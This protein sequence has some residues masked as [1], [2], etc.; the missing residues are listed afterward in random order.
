MK[1]LGIIFVEFTCY[2]FILLFC[3]ASISKILDFENF[4]IQIGQSPLLSAYAGIVS[5]FTIVIEIVISFLLAIPTTRRLGLYSSIGLMGAFTA[6]IYIILNY[7]EFI[8]CSCGGILEKMDW[9]THL[10]FNMGC[11]FIAIISYFIVE[12]D[13]NINIKRTISVVLFMLVFSSGIVVLLYYTSEYVIKKENNFIRRFPHH[14]VVEIDRYDLK[15]NSFYFAGY[16]NDKIYLGNYTSPF[17]LTEISKDLKLYKQY[18][19]KPE[20]YKKFKW[21]STKIKVAPPYVFLYDG[22]IPVIYK[23]Q[24]GQS[25]MKIISE[26]DA[27]F[28]DLESV[29]NDH[30]AL[31]SKS[32]H[33]GSN[34]L[35]ILNLSEDN[36]VKLN[37]TSLD[38]NG[39][40][41]T[42]G[43]L[44]YSPF[45]E[46]LIY[47]YY[48][49]NRFD[50][51]DKTIS[52]K[53]IHHTIDTISRPQIKVVEM[54]NGIKKM[55]AP[56]Q[57]V[58]AYA[59]VQQ[60]IL[61]NKSN[62]I[63]RYELRKH[64]KNN[65]V[66]DMY[67]ISKREYLGSFYVENRGDNKMT[68]MLATDQFFYTLIG[69]EIVRYRYAQVI[70]KQLIRESPKPIKE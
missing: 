27:Y 18:L 57:I 45:S 7:S 3:Y 58:N 63:G 41:E 16:D 11:I 70:S 25:E 9:N 13:R 10:I 30:I 56:P 39:L 53:S 35:G 17:L 1:K 5:Y 2:F 37:D 19:L 49:K 6:Y 36:Q 15:F 33:S 54:K 64:W 32:S 29:D 12:K 4:Q 26:N 67:N 21:S 23:A 66:V 60:D 65:S 52:Q 51:F 59:T 20:N 42:D 34:T 22:K 69:S 43:Q 28:S 40:F 62:L 38:G 31:R 55:A 47:V 61:F 48:Y 14:G 8:P 24:I 44:L 46:S 50:V 68:Q